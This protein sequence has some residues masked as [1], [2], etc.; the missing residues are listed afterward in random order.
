MDG[1][2]AGNLDARG[3]GGWVEAVE[4]VDELDE[5]RLAEDGDIG[6]EEEAKLGEVEVVHV[7]SEVTGASGGTFYRFFFKKHGTDA[8]THKPYPMSTFERRNRRILRL[9]KSS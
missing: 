2:G 6:G 3:V 8:N 5:V 7:L 4:G 9:T 1:G